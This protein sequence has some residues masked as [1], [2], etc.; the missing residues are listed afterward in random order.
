MGGVESAPGKDDLSN[1]AI[2]RD[3][4]ADSVCFVSDT[5]EFSSTEL[6]MR[7]SERSERRVERIE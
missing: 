3:L 4:V 7:F 2:Y 1:W 5:V 6:V